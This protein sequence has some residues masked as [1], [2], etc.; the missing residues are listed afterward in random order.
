MACRHLD[1]KQLAD[2]GFLQLPKLEPMQLTKG[3]HVAYQLLEL[4]ANG[5]QVEPC[6][7]VVQQQRHLL[8]WISGS[9]LCS[10]HVKLAHL[11]S[12][13]CRLRLCP[14]TCMEGQLTHLLL[15]WKQAE[16]QQLVGSSRPDTPHPQP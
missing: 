11:P 8:P 13:A 5:P 3:L 12:A 16:H 4:T 1:A 2:T 9:L 6:S 10:T 15:A 7:C 14:P